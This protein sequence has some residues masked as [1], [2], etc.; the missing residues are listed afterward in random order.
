MIDQNCSA[1]KT[2]EK[3]PGQQVWQPSV[4]DVIVSAAFANGRRQIHEKDDD[5]DPIEPIEVDD[6]QLSGSYFQYCQDETRRTARFVVE[7]SYALRHDTISWT[8]HSRG[9]GYGDPF[10][11]EE[12]RHDHAQRTLAR[13]LRSDGSYDPEGEVIQFLTYTASEAVR[14]CQEQRYR[15]VIVATPI[16]KVGE[17]TRTVRFE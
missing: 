15:N 14:K 13:R 3:P 4:G 1:E 10:H 9:G 6:R 7:E 11:Y 5:P 12:E 16:Y 2:E 8:R 17:M